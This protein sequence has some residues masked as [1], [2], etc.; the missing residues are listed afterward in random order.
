[1]LTGPVLSWCWLG[2]VTAAKSSGG[3]CCYGRQSEGA[4]DSRLA[5]ARV[6]LLRCLATAGLHVRKEFGAE[7]EE[8]HC[9][10]SMQ[11]LSQERSG[12]R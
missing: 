11:G 9:V 5:G 3:C 8:R 10:K 1:M 12:G 2:G 7:G 4:P 6:L